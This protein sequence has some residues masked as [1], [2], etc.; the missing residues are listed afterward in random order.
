MAMTAA[1]KSR[2]PV[3]AKAAPDRAEMKGA[4]GLFF[5]L[6]HPNFSGASKISVHPPRA[7]EG[8]RVFAQ[9]GG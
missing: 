6:P 5:C 7:N 8:G 3:T 1:V 2:G 4:D 9:P